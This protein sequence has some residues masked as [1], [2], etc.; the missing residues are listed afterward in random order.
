[1]AI[2]IVNPEK[3]WLCITP[4]D[5]TRTKGVSNQEAHFSL[6]MGNYS[7]EPLQYQK[8]Q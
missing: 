8:R 7:M 5:E 3:D 2:N 6:K 4:E 1:M